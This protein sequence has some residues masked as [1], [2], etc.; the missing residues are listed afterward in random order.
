MTRRTVQEGCV[1]ADVQRSVE[2]VEAMQ[3]PQ[4]QG[5]T[6]DNFVRHAFQSG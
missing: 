3:T 1:M 4:H 5:A 6:G 2:G